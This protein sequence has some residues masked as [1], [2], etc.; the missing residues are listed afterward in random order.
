MNIEQKPLCLHEPRQNPAQ[1]S[2]GWILFVMRRFST[3]FASGKF[4]NIKKFTG[5]TQSHYNGVLL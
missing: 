3:F 4:K 5:N 2:S 1:L